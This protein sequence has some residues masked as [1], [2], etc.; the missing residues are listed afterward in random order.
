MQYDSREA[1]ADAE[2]IEV[3]PDATEASHH[4]DLD[5]RARSGERLILSGED[6]S[7]A[8]F[9]LASYDPEW[10]SQEETVKNILYFAIAHSTVS[11]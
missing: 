7:S 6:L 3:T 11:G 10:D 4:P 9:I 2:E 1:G 5:F 8:A